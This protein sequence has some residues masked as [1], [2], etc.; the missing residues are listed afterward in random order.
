M[1]FERMDV[2]LVV[3]GFFFLYSYSDVWRFIYMRRYICIKAPVSTVHVAID[4]H[5]LTVSFNLRGGCSSF[6]SKSN[7]DRNFLLY[8][9][10]RYFVS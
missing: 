8:L 1:G 7:S 3:W 6:T 9:C 2:V 4:E 10:I 5:F